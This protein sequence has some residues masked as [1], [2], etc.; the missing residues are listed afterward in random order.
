MRK[1]PTKRTMRV[2]LSARVRARVRVRVRVYW[3]E[4]GCLLFKKM[5]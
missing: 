3:S 4:D 1:K 5:F 2:R